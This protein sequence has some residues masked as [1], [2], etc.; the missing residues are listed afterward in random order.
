MGGSQ[1][2][3][4]MGAYGRV[5]GA[6][7]NGC[8]WEGLRCRRE[9][10]LMGGSQGQKGMGAYGR[11]SGSEGNG[12]LWEGLRGRREWV[13][14]RGSQGQKGMG[15]YGRVSG[16]ERTGCLWEGLRGRRDGCLWEGLRGRREWVL[17]GGSRGQ[18]GMGA[19]GR[20]LGGRREW[21][22]MG[23]VSGAEGNGCLWEGSQGQKGMGAYGR[24]SGAEG[25]GC[26]W[27]GSP[28]W[29]GDP[30]TLH[31]I[32]ADVPSTGV[33]FMSYEWMKEKMRGERSSA[34]ELRA[35]EILLAGGVAGMCNW[36]VAIP[37]D[38]LKSRFQTAP[39][40]HYKNILEVL[41]EVL[42]SEG[43]CGLY[44]GFTAAM[45]RAFP[46]NAACFLGFEASM[47]FLNWLIPETV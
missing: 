25:N 23:G 38:V 12:C 28:T 16:A 15:A 3:K 19:Y 35:T 26:L 40:N 6:E 44:R 2:Q 9:W 21:V 46:A 41:R 20:G 42:H 7:G 45:L 22:L 8:L 11:V 37:A 13:L 30:N 1:V 14:M 5:S 47:S 17:M 24:V 31:F 43:P 18:K 34:R 36:L 29:R 39:E 33:Y 27:E 4:G 10:V 32:S